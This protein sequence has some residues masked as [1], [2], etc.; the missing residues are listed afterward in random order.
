MPSGSAV[1]LPAASIAAAG[2]S[3][4]GIASGRRRISLPLADQD[5]D[6]RRGEPTHNPP[7]PDDTIRCARRGARRW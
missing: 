6:R 3:S 1:A 7:W 4:S 2:R 5:A